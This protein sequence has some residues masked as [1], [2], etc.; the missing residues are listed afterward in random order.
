MSYLENKKEGDGAT[1]IGCFPIRKIY[2][3]AD[4]I[5]NMETD[6]PA[7]IL[8]K[9]DGWCDEPNDLNYNKFVKLPYSASTE[10]LWREDNLYDIIVI[11]GYNDN[12]VIPENGSVIF[13]HIARPNYS[14]TA[15]CI[16]LS[17][18]DLLEILKTVSKDT[19]VC[20][21]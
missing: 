13:M 7:E 5:Q 1:P 4:R 2:Y 17:M 15:G 11:L 16:A 3:R 8:N 6:I 18:S 12:P 21:E 20:I 9:D 19:L 10:Y 14:P